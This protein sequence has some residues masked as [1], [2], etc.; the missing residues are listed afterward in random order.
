MEYSCAGR[1]SSFNDQEIS[2]CLLA[3]A[4]MEHV[5]VSLLQ[6]CIPQKPRYQC[7]PACIQ[8]APDDCS[9]YHNAQS[10][11]TKHCRWVSRCD[12]AEGSAWHVQAFEKDITQPHRVSEFTSQALSN[13]AWSFATL[14][15]YPEQVLEI[16]SGELHRRIDNL[17]PQVLYL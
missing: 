2:N 3:F 11:H 12:I 4:K 13:M 6:A 16:I 15:W 5:D 1:I 14:R 7:T 9:L 10:H 17:Y 8:K